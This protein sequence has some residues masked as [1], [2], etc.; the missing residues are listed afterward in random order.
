MY[1]KVT[2]AAHKCICLS[3]LWVPI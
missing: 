2:Y 1:H 3:K